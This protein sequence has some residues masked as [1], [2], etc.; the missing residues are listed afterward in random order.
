[1]DGDGFFFITGR[2]NDMII[3]GGFNVYPKEVKEILYTHPKVALA[4][5]IG[6][7]DPKS[8]ETVKAVVQLKPGQEATDQEI[9]NFCRQRMAGYKRPRQVEFR[10]QLPPSLVGKVLR[11]ILRKEALKGLVDSRGLE[12]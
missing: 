6:L 4:A 9:L 1:M 10:D 3:V 7:P 11:R 8:G 12:Q 2:M 5:V